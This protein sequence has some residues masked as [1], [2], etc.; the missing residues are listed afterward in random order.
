M[1]PRGT[2]TRQ[3]RV[4]GG[5]DCRPVYRAARACVYLL[6][7]STCHVCLLNPEVVS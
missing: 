6:A 3:V 5:A 1:Y 4:T 2:A 7:V